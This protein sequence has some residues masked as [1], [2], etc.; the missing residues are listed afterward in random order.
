M[1]HQ[2]NIDYAVQGKQNCNV[3]KKARYNKFANFGGGSEGFVVA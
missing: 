3:I 2:H 1:A